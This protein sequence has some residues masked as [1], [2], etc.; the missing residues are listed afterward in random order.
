MTLERTIVGIVPVVNRIQSVA[1]KTNHCVCVHVCL[2]YTSSSCVALF[3][4]AIVSFP[5]SRSS[6][7]VTGA[8]A[9]A[10]ADAT[11]ML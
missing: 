1:N 2:S 9:A 11:D 10:A 3:H 7:G 5:C 6:N 8:A 4:V